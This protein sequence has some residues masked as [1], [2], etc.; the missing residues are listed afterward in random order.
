VPISSIGLR[1]SNV[2]INNAACELR[3]GAGLRVKVLEVSLIQVTGTASS[4]GFGK[5]AV[6]GVTPGT[7]SVPVMDDPAEATSTLTAALTWGTSPT[8]PNPYPRRWNSAATVGVGMV[9]TFP[10]G[11]VMAVSSSVV[12]FNITASVALDVNFACDE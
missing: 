6:I 8:A 2:T 1:T 10:R 3:T 5:P 12:I 11:F 7:T 4:F 9:W